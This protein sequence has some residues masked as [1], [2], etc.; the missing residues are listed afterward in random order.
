[1]EQTSK[2]LEII[3]TAIDEIN[4]DLPKS[5]K[6]EKKPESVLFGRD[7][8]LDSLG[9]VNLIV[10][11]ESGINDEFDLDLTLVNEKAMSLKNS[12]F[13]SVQS[14]ADYVESLL[15]NSNE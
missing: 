9:L 8:F 1:M 14:L 4:L 2:I 5:H 3:Y 11:V 12:P 15:V 13:K 6:I 7:S 10:A